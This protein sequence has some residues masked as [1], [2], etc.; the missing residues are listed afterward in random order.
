ME[1]FSR[2]VQLRP[3]KNSAIG[4]PVAKPGLTPK[5]LSH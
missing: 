4:E 5:R 2:C 1:P 3:I